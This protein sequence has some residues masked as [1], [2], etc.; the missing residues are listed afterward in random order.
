MILHNL[1]LENFRNYGSAELNLGI[2]KGLVY[3]IG[4]NAQGKTNLLEAIYILFLGRSFL[5]AKNQ[6]L[7]QWGKDFSRITGQLGKTEEQFNL[8]LFLGLP[9]NPKRATKINGV[10]TTLNNYIG[11]GRVVL[12]HPMDLNMMYLGPVTRR[13]FLDN[14]NSQTR[15]G[16]LANLRQYNKVIKQKNALLKRIKNGDAKLND[17]DIWNDLIA[18]E[19][20]KITKM[21]AELLNKINQKIED[22]YNSIAE[23][24]QDIKVIYHSNLGLD[25]EQILKH[26]NLM[27]FFRGRLEERKTTEI[28]AEY[29]LIGPQRDDFA[30][31]MKGK[32]INSHASR[33]EIRTMMLALKFLEMDLQKDN[34]DDTPLLLLDDVLSELDHQR[35][36]MLLKKVKEFQTIITTTKDSATINQEKLLPGDFWEVHNGKI[37]HV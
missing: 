35:Q 7:I 22:S 16:Y 33:G 8:E 1:K 20:S 19:G 25:L 37:S 5:R 23:E 6:N 34:S 32:N 11:M 18:V 29:S 24:K 4:D 12:F 36:L 28:L 9:P 14:I 15:K 3:L 30:I 27:N 17:L 21:R 2:G 10:K 13:D 31:E 26:E